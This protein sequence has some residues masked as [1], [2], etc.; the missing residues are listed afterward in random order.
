PPLAWATAAA[1]LVRGAVYPPI[2]LANGL[3]SDYDR[4]D[5]A[6]YSPL[7]LLLG[8]GAFTVARDLPRRRS[9][10]PLDTVST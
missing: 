1:L 9:S 7:C 5:L 6:L 2:D 4:I 8:L 3:A 10:T